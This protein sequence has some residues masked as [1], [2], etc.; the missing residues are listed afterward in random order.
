MRKLKKYL[1]ITFMI[2]TALL[3]FSSV[4][5]SIFDEV[6]N[7]VT[8]H[9]VFVVTLI[10]YFAAQI[11]LLLTT[12]MVFTHFASKKIEKNNADLAKE[13]NLLFANIAHD[14]KT[15]LTTVIGFSR[16]L[17]SD[18][19]KDEKE[20]KEMLA[21]I[22]QKSE[23]VN[24]LLDL[25]FQYTKLNTDDFHLIF[26]D[27]DLA[28]LLRETTSEYYSIFEDKGINLEID[29]PDCAVIVR[30]GRMEL[31]RALS[32]LIIN[33]CQHNAAGSKVL[34]RLKNDNSV[35]VVIA[36]DGV[37]IPSEERLTLF[38]PFISHDE[39]RGE[40]AGN[41]L[42]LA[43]TKSIVDK[44]GYSLEIKDMRAPYT[45]AFVITI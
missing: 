36:D 32:N 41:G 28:R 10:I 42:G 26:E 5:D 33:A 12:A 8:T 45:K 40:T 9:G 25:M 39:S 2:C 23:K 14:L 35:K 19:V 37:N 43:I 34:V 29:I 38:D 11:L 3:I 27:Y 1:A 18:M 17:H 44:S 21:A 31:Q 7:H 22:V 20:Q 16:A 4:I 13:R 15:P 6:V 30:M 24:N